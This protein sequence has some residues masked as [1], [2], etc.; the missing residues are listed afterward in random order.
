MG[1][2][3]IR[4]Q[5][6]YI[7]SRLGCSWAS[8]FHWALWII[9]LYVKAESLWVKETVFLCKRPNKYNPVL[10]TILIGQNST[11]WTIIWDEFSL[12]I[13]FWVHDNFQ[14]PTKRYSMEIKD[15]KL[16]FKAKETFHKQL[17]YLE[18]HPIQE[19][20][21]FIN[22]NFSLNLSVVFLIIELESLRIKI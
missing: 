11:N 15:Q 21:R 22:L 8:Y 18:G 2:I 7:D 4:L 12:Q 5:C 3:C 6:I 14:S 9:H 16:V 20:S 13:Y 1:C 10:P 19:R 17:P